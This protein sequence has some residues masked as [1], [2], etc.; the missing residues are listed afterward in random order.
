L[1][2]PLGNAEAHDKPLVDRVVEL[3]PGDMLDDVNRAKIVITNYHVFKL[4]ERIDISKGGRQLLKGRTGEE[5]QTLETEGQMLQRLMSDLMGMKNILDIIDEA[6]HC[7]RRSQTR[8]AT[9]T[10]R[11]TRKRKQRKTTRRHA[12][13]FPAWRR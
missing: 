1:R 7:Y 13:G 11:V 3:V 4:R 5:V 2:F 9:K 6:H 8:T 10:S 12:S